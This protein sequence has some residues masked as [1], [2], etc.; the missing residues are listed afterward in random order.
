MIETDKP[1]FKTRGIEEKLPLVLQMYLWQLMF[2]VKEN[3][4]YLQ[5]FE[6]KEDTL[7]G[8]G[9]QVIV[10]SQEEPEMTNTHCYV[11]DDP[12]SA[13]VYIIEDSTH[14]TMLLSSEY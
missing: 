12:I 8:D 11:T 3:R 9:L 4:D 6:L 13:R 14:F 10:H 7:G 5:V 2:E 1:C